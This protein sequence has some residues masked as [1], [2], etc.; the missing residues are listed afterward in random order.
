MYFKV[1]VSFVIV[2][3]HLISG[4]MFYLLKKAIKCIVTHTSILKER[5]LWG[6]QLQIQVLQGVKVI[7]CMFRVLQQKSVPICN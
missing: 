5:T 3:T 4:L 6:H 2:L 1:Y 7:R